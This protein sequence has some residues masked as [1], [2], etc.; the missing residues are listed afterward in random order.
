LPFL[1]RIVVT[2]T[3]SDISATSL[4]PMLYPQ[5]QTSDANAESGR[6]GTL[7]NDDVTQRRLAPLRSRAGLDELLAPG[8]MM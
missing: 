7:K 2:N 4:T 3:Y 5:A 1:I 8:R 6:F